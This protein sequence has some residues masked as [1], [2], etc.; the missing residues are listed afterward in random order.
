MS[1]TFSLYFVCPVQVESNFLLLSDL[2]RLTIDN[3]KV[4]YE[5]EAEENLRKGMLES[6]EGV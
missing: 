4:W 2:V 3:P 1:P 5:T 6:L